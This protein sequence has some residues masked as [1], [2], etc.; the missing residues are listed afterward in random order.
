MKVVKAE[1]KDD[2]N[3]NHRKSNG[4]CQVWK[5]FY[6]DDNK[7]KEVVDC[8]IY[9]PGTRVYAALWINSKDKFIG[10]TGWAGGYGYHKPSAAVAEA[11]N[12]AG[13][14]LNESINA[15]G[16]SAIMDA[17][18]TIAKYLYPEKELHL[19]ECYP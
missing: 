13:I 10:T 16:D 18:M 9:C 2:F 14:E 4:F 12:K 19:I 15:R 17:L 11:I 6:V 3:P 1:L 7:I 8:R 5:V